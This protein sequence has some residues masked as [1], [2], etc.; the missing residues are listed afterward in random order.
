MERLS[1]KGQTELTIGKKGMR[2]E[3]ELK[4]MEGGVKKKEKAGSGDLG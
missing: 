3:E 1:S 4:K 2:L